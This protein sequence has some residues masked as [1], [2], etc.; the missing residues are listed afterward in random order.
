M[1]LRD[2]NVGPAF[3][4]HAQRASFKKLN[5]EAHSDASDE[6][7][8]YIRHLDLMSSEIKRAKVALIG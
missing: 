3:L 5:A 1:N 7:G 2:I 4:A 8:A 6:G